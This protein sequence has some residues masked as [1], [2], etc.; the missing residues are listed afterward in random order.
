MLGLSIK[1]VAEKVPGTPLNIWMMK[2]YG[3]TQQNIQQARAIFNFEYKRRSDH[4]HGNAESVS[5]LLQNSDR[6]CFVSKE[7]GHNKTPV[8]TEDDDDVLV[9]N[10]EV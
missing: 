5:S 10:G 2:T 7:T 6:V 1:E 3:K 8:F 9:R 4:K